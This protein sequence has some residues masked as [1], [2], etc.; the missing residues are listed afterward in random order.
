MKNSQIPIVEGVVSEIKKRY[1]LMDATDMTEGVY[2]EFGDPTLDRILKH[3]QKLTINYLILAGIRN[4]C[5]ENN[6]RED[7][8][9]EEHKQTLFERVQYEYLILK[10]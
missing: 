10:T 8:F 5:A 9:R 3:S 6:I 1:S 7:L 4:Y 2:D